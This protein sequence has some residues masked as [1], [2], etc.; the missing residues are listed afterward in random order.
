M[1]MHRNTGLFKAFSE[2]ISLDEIAARY[3]V[4]YETVLKY[5]RQYKWR[6]MVARK[7]ENDIVRA[8]RNLFRCIR[9][10]HIDINQCGT[11]DTCV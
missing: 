1:N 3:D 2:N 10:P 9:F 11:C 4:S 5:Y 8:T 7:A 6:R